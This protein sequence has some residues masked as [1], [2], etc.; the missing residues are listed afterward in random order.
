VSE[1]ERIADT[2]L[3]SRVELKIVTA[4]FKFTYL[5]PT[6]EVIVKEW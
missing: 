3:Y 6:L 1:K 4:L 2:E 5:S